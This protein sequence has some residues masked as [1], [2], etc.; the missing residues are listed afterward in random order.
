MVIE[1]TALAE[2]EPGHGLGMFH[3][4]RREPISADSNEGC[5]QEENGKE[6]G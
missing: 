5:L 4:C 2:P 3:S 1:V 6:E